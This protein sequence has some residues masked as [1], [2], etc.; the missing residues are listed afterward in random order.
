MKKSPSYVLP[1]ASLFCAAFVYVAQEMNGAS[2]GCLT[3]ILIFTS[4]GLAIA[5][6]IRT[7]NAPA[8]ESFDAEPLWDSSPNM[9]NIWAPDFSIISRSF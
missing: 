6:L 1:I 7:S 2:T 5:A 3:A 4:L 9:R 8:D